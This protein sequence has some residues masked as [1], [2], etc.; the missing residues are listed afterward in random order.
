MF[1][2]AVNSI[3]NYSNVKYVKIDII[4]ANKCNSLVLKT[5]YMSTSFGSPVGLQL[6]F[7]LLEVMIILVIKMTK[8]PS[9]S[10]NQS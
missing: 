5:A 8:N 3:A 9:Q 4:A 10:P 6:I 7:H 1:V 2:M